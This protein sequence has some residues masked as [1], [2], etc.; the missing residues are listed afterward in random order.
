MK[1]KILIFMIILSVFFLVVL[2][3]IIFSSELP[4][5][6][7]KWLEEEV[8]YIITP[9]EKNVFLQLE[10]NRERELFIEAFWKH[11]DPTQGTEENE[12]K[13]EHYRRI[14]Y[15]NYALAREVPKPGWKTD[16]GRIYIILGEPHSIERFTGESQ[17]YNTEIWSYQGL[18]K[19]GLPPEFNLVFYQKRGVGEY[20]LYSPTKDGPQALL[21][22]HFGDQTNHIA[23]FQTLK[24]IN[25]TLAQTSLSLIPGES[26]RFGHL[27]LASD[28]LIQ[29]IYTISQ[30][31]LK[32]KYA[33][34]FLSYKD[35]VGI[36]YSANYI[37]NNFSVKIIKDPNGTYFVHYIVEL[38]KLSVQRYRE[39]YSTHLKINGRI[40]DLEEKTI[41]QYERSF[42]L[43]LD[44]AKLKKITYNPFNIYDML[45]LL[46]GEY[47]F[48]LILKNEVSK[49]F[50][51]IEKDI[52]IPEDNSH[53]K[54][55][56]LILGYKMDR[57]TPA[58]NKLIPFTIGFD[59]IH[60]QP[61]NIF[62]PQE[63]L[64]LFFQ[65]FNLEAEHRLKGELKFEFFKGD[66]QFMT[67][68]RKVSEYQNGINFKEELALQK[69]PPEHYRI[70]VVLLDGNRELISEREEFDITSASYISRP[71]VH[72]RVL[73]PSNDPVYSSILGK[74]F[75]NKGEIEKA[76]IKL[77]IAY[78]K[79]PNSFPYALSLAQVY[80]ILK[81]YD[82]TTQILLPFSD[83]TEIPYQG[84][85]L[86]GRSHQALEEFNKAVLFYNKAVSHFGINLDLLNSLGECYFG[87]GSLNEALKAWEKSLEINP[88][89][90]EIT[91][92]IKAI[93]K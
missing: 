37:D 66:E 10:T 52:I 76:R 21:T 12:F 20:I 6:H 87:L 25:H 34:K 62:H 61:I 77:E 42:P 33:E 58:S 17:I 16:R 80:F 73:P 4:V 40:T 67:F 41:Y 48:F 90:P 3:G 35:I 15:A 74:Q 32:D 7:K 43:S 60:H 51:T 9:T 84:Y 5:R 55:S 88:N 75:F 13:K 79:E 1:G 18:T 65:I 59:Q 57:I 92:R 47:K 30:K 68:T 71:W 26:P 2:A 8:V 27:S 70:K 85:L 36:D 83:S 11:R 50:T 82:K 72:Y 69:F 38:T 46:P 64:F 49:E 91:K 89:Q 44:E 23:T 24:K 56:S 93:K 78:K 29:N 63:K 86:L 22:S 81:K 39:K 28:M 45:P 53:L 54:M 31:G 14:D 19:F